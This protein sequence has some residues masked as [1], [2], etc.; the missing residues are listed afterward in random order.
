MKKHHTKRSSSFRDRVIAAVKKIP[1]GRVLTYKEVAK[2]A[3]NP[4][5]ARA[6]GSIMAANRDKNV[7]CHRVIY[8]DGT[9]GGYSGLRGKS[10]YHLLKKEGVL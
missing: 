6:V 4:H 7:P 10:K 8:S 2:R 9:L 5:A 1:K 3:G